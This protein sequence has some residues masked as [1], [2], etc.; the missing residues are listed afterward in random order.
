MSTDGI[1]LE[2]TETVNS[3]EVSSTDIYLLIGDVIS[4]G[5]PTGGAVYYYQTTPPASAT[6]TGTKGYYSIDDDWFYICVATNTW[7][8]MPIIKDT[9]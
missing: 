3:I 4:T 5:L 6:A 8:R 9:W 2:I 1:V 7:K